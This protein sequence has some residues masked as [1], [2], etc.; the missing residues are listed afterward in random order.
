MG[1]AAGVRYQALGSDVAI[2][3]RDSPVLV[4]YAD[5][6]LALCHSQEQEPFSR[7]DHEG[8]HRCGD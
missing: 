5:D 3:A 1:K 6:L 4:V 7:V 8:E 2:L